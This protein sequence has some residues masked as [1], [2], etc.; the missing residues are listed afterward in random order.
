MRSPLQVCLRLFVVGL[1]LVDLHLIIGRVEH[2]KDIALM[3]HLVVVHP[4]FKNRP[5]HA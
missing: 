2:H 4:Y 5:G 1:R 3:H